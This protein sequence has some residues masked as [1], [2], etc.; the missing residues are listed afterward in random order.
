ML[1]SR[2]YV[3][4]NCFGNCCDC[5][6]QFDAGRFMELT[7]DYRQD[8]G[9]QPYE[10]KCFIQD[11]DNQLKEVEAD[12]MAFFRANVPLEEVDNKILKKSSNVI[13]DVS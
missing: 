3:C 2:E 9:F 1:D 5:Q 4:L 7:E 6:S 10:M 8:L 11:S 13:L 12:C